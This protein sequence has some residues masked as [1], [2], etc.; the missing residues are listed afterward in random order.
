M[1]LV[2]GMPDQE[3]GVQHNVS[4]YVTPV[5]G[6]GLMDTQSVQQSPFC[7]AYFELICIIYKIC[8]YVNLFVYRM[9]FPI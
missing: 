8:K 9:Y 2:L 4:H 6:A 1:T 5:V 7:S 3:C